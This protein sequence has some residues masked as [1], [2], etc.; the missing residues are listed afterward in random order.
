MT[1][2]VRLRTGSATL[3]AIV[4]LLS[5]A[6][7]ACSIGGTSSGSEG[8]D[9]GTIGPGQAA[10]VDGSIDRTTSVPAPE[11]T[12]STISMVRGDLSI[13]GFIL[14]RPG[15]NVG[16][17]GFPDLTGLVPLPAAEGVV[18]ITIDDAFLSANE[19][20]PWLTKIDDQWILSGIS[21]DG[22]CLNLVTTLTLENSY[23]NCPTRQQDESWGAG[24]DDAAAVNVVADDVV[25]RRNTIK[26]S[27]FDNDICSRNI[28]IR[29]RNALVEY[30][31]LSFARGALEVGEGSTIQFNFM[32]SFAFGADQRQQQENN[33]PGVTHN[34]AINNG[35]YT[36]VLVAGN[37]VDATYGRVSSFPE[38][39]RNQYYPN[40]YEDGLVRIGDP[41][42]GYAVVNYLLDGPGTD[43]RLEH[44]Y[45]ASVGRSFNCQTRGVENAS[46]TTG[47]DFN[48]YGADLFDWYGSD[49]DFSV[50]GG[51]A[52]LEGRCN[53]TIDDPLDPD[54]QLLPPSF[55]A[56]DR[57]Q[58][59]GCELL[60]PSD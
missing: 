2:R 51:P 59:D 20:E 25:I 3:A 34:N 39:H 40:V 31:D 8:T 4:G 53:F 19:N 37:Y 26:C 10:G 6:A 57:H 33:N 45:F 7:G 58:T 15:N 9:A 47:A 42:N 27:G 17:P 21:A 11:V 55:L 38:D 22:I 5:I 35:G 56:G 18:G 54:P 16:V 46:C 49:R 29:G 24:A 12:E 52:V 32:H 43:F 48:A 23:V 36:D 28:E 50:S 41:I 30:N 13:Y 44:N 60:P 1:G 14:P